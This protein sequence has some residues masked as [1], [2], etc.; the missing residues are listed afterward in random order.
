MNPWCVASIPIS[1]PAQTFRSTTPSGIEPG[2]F[3]PGTRLRTWWQLQTKDRASLKTEIQS[4]EY[5]DTSQ[6]WRALP[7]GQVDIFWYGR[8][9]NDARDL[10]GKAEAALER[11]RS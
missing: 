8:D 5:A 3:A 4:F 1:R 10:L 9:E 7:G 2:Q 6:Q 11:L